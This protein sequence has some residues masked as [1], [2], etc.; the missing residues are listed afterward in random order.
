M[1]EE[2]NALKTEKKQVLSEL[3]Y[4]PNPVMTYSKANELYSKLLDETL[5]AKFLDILSKSWT[6]ATS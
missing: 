3:V 2:L 6:N 4:V 1:I 5:K